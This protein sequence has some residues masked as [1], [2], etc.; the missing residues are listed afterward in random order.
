MLYGLELRVLCFWFGLKGFRVRSVTKL[1]LGVLGSGLE[2][3][4]TRP[5]T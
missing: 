1:G 3:F 5:V 4:K 2:G